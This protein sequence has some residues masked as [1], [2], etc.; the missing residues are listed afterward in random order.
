M[1]ILTDILVGQAVEAVRRAGALLTDPA[2]VRTVVPKS[3][4]DFVTNVDLAVQNTLRG[5]LEQLA[6]AVQ[7]LGEEGEK[8]AIDPGPPSGF[9]TLWT[10]P[11]I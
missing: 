4:T 8:T 3:R 5:R 1:R 11:P 7:F 10:A 2:A 6:P 9:W